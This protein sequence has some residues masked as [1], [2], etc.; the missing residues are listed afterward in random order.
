MI[1]IIKG[2]IAA[3]RTDHVVI[4]CAGVGY[5][6]SVSSETINSLPPIG[7]EAVL[8]VHLV[9]RDDSIQ[10]YGFAT[11]AEQELFL[12][13][14]GVPSVGPK[15]ALAVLGSATPG[16]LLAAIASGD[17]ARLQTV[18]GIGKRTA[19][20]I[21]LDLRDRAGLAAIAA[22]VE[23][24]T[25][26]DDARAVAREALVGLGMDERETERLL[27]EAEGDTA[28]QLIQSALRRSAS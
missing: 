11:E 2:E 4:D 15:V 22:G 20:R 26:S 6:L 13:L 8:Q 28:E 12:M 23:T 16:T 19:E 10:L 5:R 25:D 1:A 27:D 24:S 7:G 17:A 21:C 3:L 14:I 18:P 9:V